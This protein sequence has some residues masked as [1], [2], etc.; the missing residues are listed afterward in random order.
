LDKDFTNNLKT[1]RA[2]IPAAARHAERIGLAD[3]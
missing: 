2:S 1:W 3:F